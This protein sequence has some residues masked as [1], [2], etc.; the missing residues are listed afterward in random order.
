MIVADRLG[1]DPDD[2]EVLH[3]DT[4]ISPLG[5]DTYGSRSL[6]V[7]GTAIWMATERVVEKASQIA[8]HMLEA[9]A[10]DLEL[11]NGVFNVKGTPG[12]EVPLAEVAFAAFTA[13]DL[14]EGLE[15]NLQAEVTWDP[16]NFTFPFGAH[17]ALVEIDEETGEVEVIDYAA[18]DDCGN[19][20]NPMIVEGQVHGGIVQGIGQALWEEAIYDEDGQC[21]STNLGD[22]LVPSAAETIDMKLDHTVTPSP[23][24][25]LGVKGIGE[26]G[27]IASTPAVMNAVVDALRHLGVTEMAMPAS[28]MR[29][30]RSI[31][32]AQGGAA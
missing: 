21:R 4:A 1:V 18:V 5:L 23:T 7:G 29:V 6:S 32:N 20:I 10:E 26:A 30:R 8:A 15:P 31:E 22:Y 27:T 12:A 14:P 17:I 28:P 9:N 2:V 13:H 25:P 3:S 24:N 11:A 16:P 19:Q